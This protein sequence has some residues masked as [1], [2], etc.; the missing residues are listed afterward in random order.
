MAIP[1][2]GQSDVLLAKATA[3]FVLTRESF[4]RYKLQLNM[5]PGKTAFLPMAGGSGS[6]ALI[7]VINDLPNKVPRACVP[8]M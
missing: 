3:T 1:V 2:M 6:E 4:M 5:A 7:R 8:K